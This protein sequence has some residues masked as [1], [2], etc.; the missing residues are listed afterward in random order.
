MF[1][2]L[3]TERSIDKEEKNGDSE[4]DERGEDRR[5]IRRGKEENVEPKKK[6]RKIGVEQQGIMENFMSYAKYG[7]QT[8]AIIY[9]DLVFYSH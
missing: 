5:R 6:G 2:V 7:P 1:L 3:F 4:K 8:F 9:I